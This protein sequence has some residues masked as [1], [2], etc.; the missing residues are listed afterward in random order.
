M[1]I[2]FTEANILMEL[3]TINKTLVQA[4]GGCW[5]EWKVI[6]CSCGAFK[7]AFI[8]PP[9]NYTA[10]HL[11]QNPDFSK[12]ENFGRLLK[13]CRDIPANKGLGRI[14]S[15]ITIQVCKDEIDQIPLLAATELARILKYGKEE[16]Q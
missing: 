12:W 6:S 16:K 4:E 1:V 14:E 2:K 8:K 9:A 11:K 3:D 5:H 13:I 7:S 10:V 15:I